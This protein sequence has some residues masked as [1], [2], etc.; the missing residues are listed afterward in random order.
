M[1]T[2]KLPN[3]SNSVEKMEKQVEVDES[4]KLSVDSDFQSNNKKCYI[5]LKGFN[6]RK[7]HICK[8]CLS[9]VCADHCQRSMPKEPGSEPVP[10]CDLCLQGQIKRNIEHELKLDIQCL[11]EELGQAKLTNSRLERDHFEKTASVSSLENKLETISS[12]YNKKIQALQQSLQIEE[13]ES[14]EIKTLFNKT[15]LGL[16]SSRG[17]LKDIDEKIMKSKSE[18]E[19]QAKQLE[20]LKETKEGLSSQLN[21]INEKLKGS[22]AIEKVESILCEQCK[23]KMK[24]AAQKRREIPS[25]LEDATVNMTAIEERQSVLDSVRE[26]KDILEK[27]TKNPNESQGCEIV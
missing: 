1:R 12:D 5:C 26:Y 17:Q 2:Y 15:Q 4:L 6:F 11:Q 13:M 21:R 19:S 22:L 16:D 18:L 7:K 27:Q 9:A 25:I 20:N 23:N 8:F 24:E 14:K 10:I 3:S